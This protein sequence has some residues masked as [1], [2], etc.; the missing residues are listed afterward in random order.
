M[1]IL[2]ILPD[3]DSFHQ[4]YIH[5]GIA[6]ISGFLKANGYNDIRF[7]T[8]ASMDDYK[9]IVNK[10][11]SFKPDIIGFTSVETQFSNVINL[12][13]LIK[14]VCQC[15]IVC[16]GAFPTLYP[17]CIKDAPYLDGIFIGESELAFLKFVRALEQDKDYHVIENFCF[18][19][20]NEDRIIKNSL[21][22][23][24]TDLDRLGFPDRSIFNFQDVI[25]SYGGAA[26][27][28]FNR[29]CPYN[30]SFCSNHA[31][32]YVYGSLKNLIR[33]R[34]VDSCIA[35]IKEVVAEYKFDVI[36]VWD[37]LFTTNRKWLYEF[38]ERYK[39]EIKKPFMC[40]TRSNLCNDE[41]FEKLNE[42]GCYK[43]HMSLESG[44]DFI[45]NVVMKRNISR[46]TVVKSFELAHRY[47][48]EVSASSIIGLPFETEDMIKETIELLGLLKVESP[49]IN[50]FYPYKGTRLREICEEYGFMEKEMRYGIQ[51]RRES[52]LNLPHISKERLQ[53]YH[54]N[55]EELVRQK[56]G[57]LPYFLC[58]TKRAVKKFLPKR[59]QSIIRK[60]G[61]KK[62]LHS[63]FRLI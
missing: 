27:F 46:D 50:I 12:T 11:A 60:P 32:A 24:E 7:Q 8:V 38:L 15:V 41:L 49:G 63:V 16:G 26:P 44:N 30:C 43:V 48:I 25:N 33:M 42:G 3:V 14:E 59:I 18:Y 5:F 17:E 22:P 21:L 23:K 9:Q 6:Y 58:K 31:L 36:H 13:R 4:L 28:M 34:S 10:A 54:D 51:E 29:G 40:T 62:L 57:I 53:Y 35:E 1:K 37:D 45:R 39:S 2:F 56:E 52:V 61:V 55:F 19:D 20:K 47:G